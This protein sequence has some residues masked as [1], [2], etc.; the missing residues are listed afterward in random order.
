MT[1]AVEPAAEH[2]D[3]R[4]LVGGGAI[5]GA[6]SAVGVVAFALLTRVLDGSAALVAQSLIVLLGALL[7][8]YL[9]AILVRPRNVDGIA[10]A[11]LLGLLGALTFTVVDTAVLRPLS[12]YSWKWDAIGGGSGFWYVSVWWM[13]SAV[14]AWLGAWILAIGHRGDRAPSVTVA[15]GTTVALAAVVFAALTLSHVV[16]P[17]AAIVALAFPI[18]LLLHLVLSA[19]IA[20]R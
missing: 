6:M 16:R 11:A 2:A 8:A 9:P 18:A 17:G 20:R 3:V 15:G 14:L 12:V 10:W 19:A 4:T 7:A 5:L 13:G 1:S